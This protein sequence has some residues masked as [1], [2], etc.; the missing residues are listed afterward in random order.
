MGL[1]LVEFAFASP[2]PSEEEIRAHLRDVVG[3]DRALDSFELT[4]VKAGYRNMPCRVRLLFDM[5]NVVRPYACAFL[6]EHGG[7]LVD[8]RTKEPRELVLPAFVG[9][10]WRDWSLLQ[11]LRFRW[12]RRD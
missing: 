3:S 6:V 11:R 5:E 1:V 8:P 12:R 2:P 9:R 7:M 4:T 10:P